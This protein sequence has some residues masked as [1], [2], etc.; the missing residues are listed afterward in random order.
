[1]LLHPHAV[2]S[3]QKS[4]LKTSGGGS[5]VYRFGLFQKKGFRFTDLILDV[6]HHNKEHVVCGNK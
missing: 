1:M 5:F 2:S 3:R 6:E 4:V